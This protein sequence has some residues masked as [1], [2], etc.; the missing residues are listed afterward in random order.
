MRIDHPPHPLLG[1]FQGRRFA[2]R[3]P[4]SA[5]KARKARSTRTS[6]SKF[7]LCLYVSG[8]T[9][10]SALAVENIKRICEQHLKDRFSLTVI[11]VYQQPDQARYDQ[12]VALP[13]LIKRGPE[14]IRRLI[15]DL[16]NTHKVLLAL[17][18]VRPA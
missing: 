15:G 17:D 8:S 5:P 18:L 1:P 14:P 10:K 11:D 3:R 12:I 2:E 16:S 7:V 9:L 6:K 13:T 4:T